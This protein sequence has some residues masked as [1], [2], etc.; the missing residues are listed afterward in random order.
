M[1]SLAVHA[2]GRVE[3]HG[4]RNIF[5]VMAGQIMAAALRRRIQVSCYLLQLYRVI[6]P[7]TL[8]EIAL[9]LSGHQFPM[10]ITMPFK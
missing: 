6:C 3:A 1:Q 4:D 10:P 2:D 9:Q 8:L 7:Y 5:L